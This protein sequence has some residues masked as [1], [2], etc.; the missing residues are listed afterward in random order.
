MKLLIS[1]LLSLICSGLCWAKVD[2]KSTQPLVV[3]VDNVTPSLTPADLAKVLP[4]D[5]RQGDNEAMVLTRIADKGVSF[6]F[7]SAAVKETS[8][9]RIAQETQ[10]KLKT[11]VVVPAST[12]QGVTHKFS[13][14]IEAFQALAKVEYT[15]WLKAAI[16][17]DAKA[18]A[19]DILL[20]EKVFSNKD[21]VVTHKANKDQALSMVALGWSW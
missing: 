18:A 1:V 21:L 7:N 3:P 10:E 9:G 11:D 6:W 14:K 2:L 13:F 12:P 5:F 19:M 8:L 17:Y 16:N 20:R 4:T 15:G